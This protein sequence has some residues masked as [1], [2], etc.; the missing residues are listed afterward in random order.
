MLFFF[1][2]ALQLIVIDLNLSGTQVTEIENRWKLSL[3]HIRVLPGSGK[4]FEHGVSE[5]FQDWKIAPIA[6]CM[7]QTALNLPNNSA[8][9][10]T[11]TE[12]FPP[13]HVLKRP[14]GWFML[15]KA[16]LVLV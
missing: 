3:S 1:S 5:P 2:F 13:A 15:V 7:C 9:G 6:M 4:V 16:R 10:K 11:Q 14:G 12:T 8:V